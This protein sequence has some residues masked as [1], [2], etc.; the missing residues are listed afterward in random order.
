MGGGRMILDTAIFTVS[1][2]MIIFSASNVLLAFAV[3][4]LEKATQTMHMT[5]CAERGIVQMLIDSKSLTI[6]TP[7]NQTCQ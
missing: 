6:A 4:R 7:S 2:A 3:R 1:L 5:M